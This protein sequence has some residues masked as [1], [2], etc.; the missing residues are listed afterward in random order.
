MA[1][2]NTLRS[3][4]GPIHSVEMVT[5]VSRVVSLPVQLL[6]KP[7]RKTECLGSKTVRYKYRI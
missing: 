3:A 6:T 5:L 1:S 7:C 4:C 2:V